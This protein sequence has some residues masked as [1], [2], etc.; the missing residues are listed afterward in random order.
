M[1]TPGRWA[2]ETD[3]DSGWEELGFLRHHD[4]ECAPRVMGS[5]NEAECDGDPR[6]VNDDYGTDIASVLT[7]F[8]VFI[9]KHNSINAILI[10][11]E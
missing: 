5:E 4:D 10:F 7:F 6:V 1:G 9:F 11:F 2:W 3:G 8:V